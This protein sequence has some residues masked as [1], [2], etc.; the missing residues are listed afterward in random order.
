M[1]NIFNKIN[2]SITVRVKGESVTW[3][4]KEVKYVES[5]SDIEPQKI[6]GKYLVIKEESGLYDQN[7]EKTP[8]TPK[9]PRTKGLR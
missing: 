6:I 3:K 2:Q 4:S 8:G 9:K 7:N 5:I 1:P